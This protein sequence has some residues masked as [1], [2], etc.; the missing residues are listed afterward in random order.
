[1]SGLNTSGGANSTFYV[2]EICTPGIDGNVPVS[3]VPP[4][5]TTSLRLG[6]DSAYKMGLIQN[7]GA[8]GTLFPYNH[9]KIS[10]T[11]LVTQANKTI[12]YWYAVAL[13]Q[14]HDVSGQASPHPQ[15]EQPFFKI[16][17]YD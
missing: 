13:S 4:G 7:G 6:N 9:Q 14:T 2:H 17:M 15:P 1:M 12:T 16:R 11:F 10:N 8:V 3:R 5:H